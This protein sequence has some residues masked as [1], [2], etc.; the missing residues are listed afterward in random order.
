MSLFSG[1]FFLKKILSKMSIGQTCNKRLCLLKSRSFW[2]EKKIK[3]MDTR[4]GLWLEAEAGLGHTFQE[5][6][7][8]AK[9]C[10]TKQTSSCATRNPGTHT[11]GRG[12]QA[13]RR[14]CC[15]NNEL[16]EVGAQESGPRFWQ[17]EG[18]AEPQ[19]RDR[20]G[21][22]VGSSLLFPITA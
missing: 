1:F 6:R 18:E 10:A 17:T 8:V 12:K 13:E 16:G 3:S 2:R 11:S 15:R 21:I 4:E 5:L 20:A 19:T 14:S 22:P 9:L 7:P